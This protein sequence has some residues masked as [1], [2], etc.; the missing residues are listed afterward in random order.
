MIVPLDA[1]LYQKMKLTIK[2]LRFVKSHKYFPELKSKE[3]ESKNKNK[4]ATL[5]CQPIPIELESQSYF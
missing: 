4:T 5:N 3:N 1:F 2:F